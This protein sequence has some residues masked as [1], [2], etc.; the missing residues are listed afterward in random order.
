MEF[1]S[2]GLF[3]VNLVKSEQE[4][5]FFSLNFTNIWNARKAHEKVGIFTLKLWKQGPLGVE[6]S[7]KRGHWLWDLQKMGS[8]CRWYWSTF[9]SVPGVFVDPSLY[10]SSLTKVQVTLSAQESK[11]AVF[12]HFQFFKLEICGAFYSNCIF[13]LSKNNVIQGVSE[14]TVFTKKQSLTLLSSTW[15]YCFNEVYFVLK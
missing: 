8:K 10:H 13:I 3:C 2:R 4:F 9:E 15:R 11:N 5:A 1:Q 7:G 6:C 14:R 12:V